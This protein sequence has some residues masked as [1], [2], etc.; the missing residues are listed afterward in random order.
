MADLKKQADAGK[1]KGQ[2]SSEA[3][4]Q[5]VAEAVAAKQ[6]V[7]SAQKELDALK[8]SGAPADQIAAAEAKVAD[9]QKQIKP[10]TTR[11]ALL[12]DQLAPQIDKLIASAK[13]Q[14]EIGTKAA[15]AAAAKIEGVSN[16]LNKAAD[17]LAAT[18]DSVQADL[19]KLQSQLQQSQTQAQQASDG[20]QEE[21]RRSYCRRAA[22]R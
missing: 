10:L 1:P 21:L 14:T 3:E 20:I 11:E 6:A 17:E 12:R 15:A 16:P 2:K 7:D 8:K 19:D 9:L 18:V 13:Q 4:K 22:G 5:A